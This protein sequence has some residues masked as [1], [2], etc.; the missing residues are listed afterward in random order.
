[1]RTTTDTTSRRDI[2]TPT[3][4]GRIS[5][6]FARFTDSEN[7][8]ALVMMG[9]TVLALLLA[10]VGLS[11][12]FDH[13]WHTELGISLGDFTFAQSLK[14]WIDDALMAVF[15]FVVG[16]EIKREVI[17]GELSSLREAALPVLAALGGMVVPAL[18]Y[19]AFN[20][21]GAGQA[22]WGIPMATDIAFAIAAVT[23]LGARVPSSLKVFL[24]ALAIADDIGAIIV[25]AIFYAGGV[26]LWWLAA[27][28]VVAALMW[29]LGRLRV[30]ALAPYA[31]LAVLMWFA[32]LNS[33]VHATI[34]GVIAALLIPTRARVA[35]LVF[36]RFARMKVG[37]IEATDEPGS[38]VL[39]DDAQQRLAFELAE[40]ATRTASPLQRA[41][42]ALLPLVNLGI[43]P[44]FALANAAVVVVGGGLNFGAVGTGVYL[45]LVLG[46]PLGVIG[47]TWIGVRLGG[48]SLPGSM[49]WHDV[50]G[51]G[52]LAGIGFTMSIFVANLA[53]GG[54]GELLAEA[55]LAILA[56]SAT[57]GLAGYLYLRR[58]STVL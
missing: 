31:I 39:A 20:G 3:V 2:E 42:H 53:F 7:A 1:M 12:L 35:P 27:A 36:A 15:F 23:V 51:A 58:Y 22:G 56:A 50:V 30:D 32:L 49:R 4:P 10:N 48:L 5:A 33:G 34:G 24:T 52:L 41:E 47:A 25:I 40:A 38:H 6:T 44:L 13:L 8:G 46:K 16:L 57:A 21:G 43:L 11:G 28:L 29:A 19:A 45:G 55:K 37:Q 26:A 17:V 14:H 54:A 9:A 18:I